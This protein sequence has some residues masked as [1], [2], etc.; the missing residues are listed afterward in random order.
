M[1]VLPIDKLVNNNIIYKHTN[2]KTLIFYKVKLIILTLNT[3]IPII[4]P[5]GD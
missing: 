4:V 3:L 5:I 1:M 2:K